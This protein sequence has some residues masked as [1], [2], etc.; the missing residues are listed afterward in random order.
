MLSGYHGDKLHKYSV[1]SQ[2]NIWIAQ[3]W[4]GGGGGG[5]NG[6]CIFKN[7]LICSKSSKVCSRLPM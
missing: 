3:G 7:V 5:G 6:R 1:I 2:V 4:G